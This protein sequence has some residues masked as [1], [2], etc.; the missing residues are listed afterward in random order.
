MS[1][2]QTKTDVLAEPIHQLETAL[3]AEVPGHE[4]DWA[5]GVENALT[6]VDQGLG[7][8]TALAETPD[9]LLTKVDL[10]RPTSVRQVSSL[11]R[12]HVELQEQARSLRMQLHIAAQAFQEPHRRLVKT[13]ETLPEPAPVGTV[14]DF[15]SIRQAIT[16]LLAALR[17]HQEE[18]TKLVLDSMNTDI[19]VGD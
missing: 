4:G 7:L 12:E 13:Q 5:Q 18:E 9:G 3:A 17:Q 10:T 16:Q 1:S 15:S 11:R 6:A 8:H 19:G 2:T 14:A